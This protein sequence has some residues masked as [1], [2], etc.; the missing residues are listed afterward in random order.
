MPWGNRE[1]V[2]IWASESNVRRRKVRQLVI[3]DRWL[4]E[5]VICEELN[6]DR[7]TVGKILTEDLEIHHDMVH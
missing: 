3:T 7:V 6:L 1:E 4:R 5:W 2:K